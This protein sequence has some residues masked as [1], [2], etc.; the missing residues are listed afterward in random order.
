MI[1][2]RR[3]SLLAT[4]V[5]LAVSTFAAASDELARAKD[6]YRSASYDEALVALNEIASGA[7]GA[8]RTEA[9]EYRL[10]CLIALD[11]KAEARTA[12]EGMVNTDPFYV[13]SAEQASPR[14][15]TISHIPE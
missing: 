3:S 13:L 14:V 1:A 15:R 8:A 10:F 7:T 5:I 4:I 12:I 6:L 11:R 2:V 9:N